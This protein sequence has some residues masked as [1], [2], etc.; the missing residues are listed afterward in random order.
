MSSRVLFAAVAAGLPIV[1][2]MTSGCAS[3]SKPT[4]FGGGSGGQAPH[5]TAAKALGTYAASASVTKQYGITEWR[6]FFGNSQMVVTGY[7]SDGTA[8]R[9]VQYAWF[10]PAQ[11]SVGHTRLTMLDGSGAVL[12]RMVGGGESGHLSSEQIAFMQTMRSDVAMGRQPQVRKLHPLDEPAPSYGNSPGQGPQCF[13][14]STDPATVLDGSGCILG[15]AT[16]ETVVGGLMAMG[17]C[18]QWYLDNEKTN[19]T[20]ANENSTYCNNDNPPTCNYGQDPS[21]QNP[22]PAPQAQCDQACIC[23]NYG[24]YNGM[25]CSQTCV[26]NN[27]CGSGQECHWGSCGPAAAPADSP[28][29]QNVTQQTPGTS[30]CTSGDVTTDP[31]T[32][33]VGC[34]TASGGASS[35]GGSSGGA[36]GSGSSSGTDTTGGDPTG[37]SSGGGPSSGSS[38]GGQCA[39]DGASC[40]QDSDCCLGSC[41][42]GTCGV[43][44]DGSSSGGSGGGSGSSSGGSCAADGNACAQDSDCCAGTC[45]TSSGTC[46]AASGSSSGG[47]GSGSSSGG[48]CAPD[49]SACAQDADCC[50]GTCDTSTGTCG[51]ASGSSSGGSG[52]SSGGSCAADGNACSQA[53]DCCSGA[54]TSGT[55][56][57]GGGTTCGNPGD[58]CAQGSDCC[59]GSCDTS[60]GTCN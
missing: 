24:V 44:G 15:A 34:S 46:G 28:T 14:A 35:S 33:Q 13:E 23:A 60:A 26:D 22:P 48:S 40:S 36:S 39:D 5:T 11:G 52:S 38:G 49:G 30:S 10:A 45:D 42:S 3:G 50:T 6:T 21:T 54:C 55:C 25:P 16:F 57:T 27:S 1:V 53:S 58:A 31:S 7:R 59:S 18:A 9:G 43:S 20:C 17:T 51:A 41:G 12:R 37:G 19:M 4:G 2:A 56:G 29:N 8:A 32:G 47:S